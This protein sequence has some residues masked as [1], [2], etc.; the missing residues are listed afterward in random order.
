LIIVWY[1]AIRS[2]GV[3]E[4]PGFRELARFDGD[5]LNQNLLQRAYRFQVLLQAGQRD[6]AQ[7]AT[8]VPL[9]EFCQ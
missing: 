2:I 1:R 6:S 3:C 8:T 7:R 9:Q 4:K 5:L